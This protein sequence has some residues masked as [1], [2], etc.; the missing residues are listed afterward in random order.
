MDNRRDNDTSFVI[1]VAAMLVM[2]VF[3]FTLTGC[4]LTVTSL[5]DGESYEIARY[6]ADKLLQYDRSFGSMELVYSD[7]ALQTPEPEST[8]TTTTTAA[9][10][11]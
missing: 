8:E 9:P 5:S 6:M 11:A 2:T 10:A 4:D 7:P 3:V 1:K